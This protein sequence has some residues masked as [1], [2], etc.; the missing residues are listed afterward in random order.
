MTFCRL[1]GA[2]PRC[3]AAA[4][5][6]STVIAA[7]LMGWLLAPA[8]F[9]DAGDETLG[10]YLA[11]SPLVALGVLI[12]EP[13]GVRDASGVTSYDG[14]F[15]VDYVLKGDATLRGST[16]K[17]SIRRVELDAKDRP[18][19]LKK[20]GECILFVHKAETGEPSWETVDYW[21]AVQPASPAMAR[22][23]KRLAKAKAPASSASPSW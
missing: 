19:Q 5:M 16:I 15:R 2:R 17:V 11:K 13:T 18:S 1:D 3:Y 23:L 21:F 10:F 9:G 6:K 7:V 4:S 22:S 12:N 14:L 8:A 20:D